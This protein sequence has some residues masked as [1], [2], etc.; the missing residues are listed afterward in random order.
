[1]VTAVEVSFTCAKQFT[2]EILTC[3][4]HAISGKT[5]P[6]KNQQDQ[7]RKHQQNWSGAAASIPVR[8]YPLVPA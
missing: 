4:Y 8:L 5:R 7:T 6:G 3:I 2:L 1:M